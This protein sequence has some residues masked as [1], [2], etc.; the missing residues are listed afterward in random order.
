MP[1]DMPAALRQQAVHQGGVVI[2]KQAAQAGLSAAQIAWLLNRGSWLRLYRGVYATFTGPVSDKARLWAAVLYA[3]EGAYLSHETAAEMNRL[4]DEKSPV[5]HVTIPVRRCVRA[6]AGM[7][8]HRSAER[9][10][11]WRVPGVPPHT[12]APRTVIDLVQAAVDEDRVIAVVTGGFGRR[13]VT[14]ADLR[15]VAQMCKKLRWRLKLEEIAG[16]AAAGAHSP[17]EYRH[18]RD[19]H[20]AHGLPDPVKLARFR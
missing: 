14:A 9:P 18:D 17:L 3:G 19:V 5:I 13:L 12:I 4:T 1:N 10:M 11:V 8:I 16:A 6:P 2:R 7:V 20:R 15:A